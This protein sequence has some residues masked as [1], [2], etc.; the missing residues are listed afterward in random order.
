MR[1]GPSLVLSVLLNLAVFAGLRPIQGDPSLAAGQTG[2]YR[3]QALRHITLHA[4]AGTSLPVVR[5]PAPE[6]AGPTATA[7]REST[8]RALAPDPVLAARSADRRGGGDSRPAGRRGGAPLGPPPPALRGGDGSQLGAREPGGGDLPLARPSDLGTAGLPN[9]GPALGHPIPLAPPPAARTRRPSGPPTLLPGL[10]EQGGTP[11]AP[12][13]GFDPLPGTAGGG[14]QRDQP[15]P[16]T[17]AGY[18][19]PAV[20]TTP[21]PR[22]R[23]M[24]GPGLPPALQA[25]VEIPFTR[26]VPGAHSGGGGGTAG[27]PGPGGGGPPLGLAPRD[28]EAARGGGGSGL[29]QAGPRPGGSTLGSGPG[30]SGGGGDGLA[31]LGSGLSSPTAGSGLRSTP[32]LGAPSI[33]QR[34][35]GGDPAGGA[36]RPGKRTPGPGGGSG[37]LAAPDQPADP[38][39]DQPAGPGRGGTGGGTADRGD[40]PGR[41]DGGGGPGR[42]PGSGPATGRGGRG[43]GG[44]GDGD[45]QGTAISRGK[46]GSSGY[47]GAVVDTLGLQWHHYPTS[48]DLRIGSPDGPLVAS[49][50]IYRAP[51]L[52]A[53][54][55]SNR[56]ARD[57]RREVLVIRPEQIVFQPQK[58]RQVVVISA[59]AAA[60]LRRSGLLAEPGRILTVYKSNY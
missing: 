20:P 26:A 7:R 43:Q 44:T 2:R 10:G 41:G 27:E 16:R 17:L 3:V 53:A 50:G 59:S 18:Q 15:A 11:T 23:S 36:A 58:A 30:G 14:D 6:P 52:G 9:S 32:T 39:P 8:R 24:P 48:F 47:T 34:P 1:F 5:P 56:V 19:A 49:L 35:A 25:P 37:P 4:P 42:G 45:G 29:S 46:S 60:E 38:T 12:Q 54:R 21:G 13:L 33:I 28:R 57:G 51:S 55:A 22:L 40:G 31:P